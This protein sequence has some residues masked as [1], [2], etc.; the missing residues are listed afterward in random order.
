MVLVIV[1]ITTFLFKKVLLNDA[2]NLPIK[3][4]LK[5]VIICYIDGF[6]LYPA[7]NDSFPFLDNLALCFFYSV[8]FAPVFISKV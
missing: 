5:I 4:R 6:R 2:L 7:E 1:H 3:K 8:A